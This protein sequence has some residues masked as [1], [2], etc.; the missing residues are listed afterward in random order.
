VRRTCASLKQKGERGPLPLSHQYREKTKKKG[1]RFF[2]SLLYTKFVIF[3]GPMV[4]SLIRL[5][6]RDPCT[7]IYVPTIRFEVKY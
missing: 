6:E 2:L 3:K 1:E 4:Q 5:R 7:R